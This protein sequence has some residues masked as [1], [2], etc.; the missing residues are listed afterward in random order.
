M[1]IIAEYTIE[2]SYAAMMKG[3]P[4][5][6]LEI[7][8][9]SACNPDTVAV[10]LWVH[11]DDF[12]ALEEVLDR[13]DVITHFE[14]MDECPNARR[15]QIRLP[16]T[17]TTYWQWVGL[18]GV[19][20]N[21]TVTTS[22]VQMQMRFPDREAL[23]AYR[24]HCQERE[25]AFTLDS[26]REGSKGPENTSLLTSCQHDTVVAAVEKGYFDVPRRVRMAELAEHFG[27]SDQATSERLRRGLSN[28]LTNGTLDFASNRQAAIPSDD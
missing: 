4:N 7:E 26:L 12:T 13:A 24:D 25:Y 6:R 28:L 5:I 17:E 22:G 11:G 8:Q 10:T 1:S 19:L 23:V 2:P 27:I 21:G 18:G 20:V 14:T 3:L 9:V 15:Y 16:A